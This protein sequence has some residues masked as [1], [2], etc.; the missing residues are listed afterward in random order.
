M[1]L[2]NLSRIASVQAGWVGNR[3]SIDRGVNSL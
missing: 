1:I 2:T 3:L